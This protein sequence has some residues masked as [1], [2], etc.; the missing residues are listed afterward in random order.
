MVDVASYF[1]YA[2]GSAVH[3]VIRRLEAKRQ[4]DASLDKRLQALEA[5]MRSVKS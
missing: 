3:Q 4:Q 5:K 2:N 1:G